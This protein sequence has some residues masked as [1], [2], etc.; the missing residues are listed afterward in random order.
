MF[1]VGRNL[2]SERCNRRKRDGVHVT[3]R[4][5]F[6]PVASPLPRRAPSENLKR[7]SL[8]NASFACYSPAQEPIFK[9]Y[10]YLSEVF[11]P[12][13][14]HPT[15]NSSAPTRFAKRY[16]P[17]NQSLT[18]PILF[19]SCSVSTTPSP[20]VASRLLRHDFTSDFLRYLL[21]LQ[22]NNLSS[23]ERYKISFTR[24]VTSFA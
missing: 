14:L 23:H 15:P 12:N 16:K 10:R 1:Q 17:G 3:K 24:G 18:P 22:L 13:L 21:E 2:D 4:R 11:I 8:S 6:S 7:F 5:K 19:Q 20:L 9:G